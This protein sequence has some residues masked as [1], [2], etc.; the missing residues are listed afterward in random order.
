MTRLPIILAAASAAAVIGGCAA[1]PAM[2]QGMGDPAAL[3]DNADA[4]HD[5]VVTRE[6]FAAARAWRFTQFDRNHDGVLSMDDFPRLSRRGGDR[7]ER[8]QTLIHALDM[9]GDGR[10]THEEMR[11]A[12]SPL[13]DRFDA[14]HDGRLDAGELAAARAARQSR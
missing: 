6:E 8:L 1:A 9:D 4:N 14:N 12:P 7:A 10:V 2:A 13:F 11:N 3:L 5:G